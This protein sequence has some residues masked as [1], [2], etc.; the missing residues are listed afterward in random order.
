MI[1]IAH[2]PE[3]LK[4]TLVDSEASAGAHFNHLGGHNRPAFFHVHTNV[5][6]CR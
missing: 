5:Y 2:E 6:T 4:A 3:L 1:P